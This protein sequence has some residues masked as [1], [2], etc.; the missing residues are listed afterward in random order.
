MNLIIVDGD[1]ARLYG[2]PKAIPQGQSQFSQVQFSFSEEWTNLRKIAQFEQKGNIY[3]VEVS[4]DRCF[5]PSELVKGVVNVRVKGYPVDTTSAVIATA[6]EV[7]LPVSVGFQSG[8]IPSAPPTPDLYQKLIEEFSDKVQSDWNQNDPTAKD[9]V[10]NRPFYTGDSVEAVLVE[11][12]TVPFAEKGDLYGVEFPST[13]EAT[14]GENYKISWDGTVYECTCVD[15]NGSNIIGNISIAG[16]GSDTGEPFVMQ[17]VN[18][19][20]IIIVTA[21]TSAS[22]T[23]SISRLVT[24]VVKIDEKYLPDTVAANIAEAQTTAD[25]AQT[26]ATSAKNA[27][28]EILSTGLTFIGSK[29]NSVFIGTDSDGQAYIGNEHSTRVYPGGVDTLLVP[30]GLSFRSYDYSNTLINQVILSVSGIK[31]KP[32][33]YLDKGTIRVKSEPKEGNEVATKSYVDATALPPVT[34]EDNGKILKVMDGAWAID[35]PSDGTDISLGLTSTTVGQIA[36]ITAVD[37]TGKPTAWEAV[38][39]PSGGGGDGGAKEFR[40]IRSITLEE[41]SDR[42]DISVDSSGNAFALHEVY[43]MLSA[44]SYEDAYH[45]VTFLPNG[46]WGAFDAYITSSSKA[47]KSS[48]T[49]KNNMVFHSMYADG[50]ICSEQLPAKGQNMN[51]SSSFAINQAIITKISIVCKFAAGC[52]FLVIGR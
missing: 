38:D 40:L 27:V 20:G 37:G 34:T 4:D 17:V 29:G 30:A 13:F 28:D 45:E 11:E 5:C 48:E 52:T 3:N 36:K 9:Y 47:S 12:R 50:V 41:Q 42:V 31:D 26:T 8:G 21:D 15:F 6:N 2:T 16:F 51:L 32:Y 25:N 19:D 23:F 7:V 46:R 22:H 24:E 14:V 43:V 1:Q 39:M 10:K 44:Q 18:G 33:L 35:I 49:W